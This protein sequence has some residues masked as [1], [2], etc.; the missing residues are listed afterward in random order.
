MNVIGIGATSTATV[1]D[2]VGI[3]AETSQ[4]VAGGLHAIA[5]LRNSAWRNLL[6]EVTNSVRLPLILLEVAALKKRDAECVTQSQASLTAYGV[7]SVAEAAALAGAGDGSRL[8]IPRIAHAK[9]TAAV[10]TSTDEFSP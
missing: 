2:I 5:A 8:I 10:A 6:G 4:K 9:V 3:I 7:G 1:D